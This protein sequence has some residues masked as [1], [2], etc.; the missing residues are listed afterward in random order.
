MKI[1]VVRSLSDEVIKSNIYDL[2]MKIFNIKVNKKFSSKEDL[3]RVKFIRRDIA[4]MLTVINQRK[5][6]DLL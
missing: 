3:Y 6:I 5:K 4:R 2:S 1:E